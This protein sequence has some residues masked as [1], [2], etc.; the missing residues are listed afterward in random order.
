M[1]ALFKRQSPYTIDVT[2]LAGDL[3]NRPLLNAT[4]A[5]T[6]AV[7]PLHEG[8]TGEFPLRLD[9]NMLVPKRGLDVGKVVTGSYQDRVPLIL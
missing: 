2:A 9:I 4:G 5:M 1:V 8:I 7:I 6:E 3:K